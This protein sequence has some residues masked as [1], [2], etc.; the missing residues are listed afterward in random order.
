MKARTAI[1]QSLKDVFRRYRSQPIDRVIALIN[2]QGVRGLLP[3]G[4]RQSLLWVRPRLGGK[5]DPAPFDARASASRLWL[6]TVD[7]AVA[8]CGIGT[9]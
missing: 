3:G 9:L 5:E 2:P 7:S 8:I 4:A 6:E 1:L